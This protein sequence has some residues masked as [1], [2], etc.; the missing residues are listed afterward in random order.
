[1]EA[2]LKASEVSVDRV[3]DIRIDASME[4]GMIQVPR[5]SARLLG[6]NLAGGLKQELGEK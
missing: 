4:Q 5:F 1:M 6:G 2:Y 3:E